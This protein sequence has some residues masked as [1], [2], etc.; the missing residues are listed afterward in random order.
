[1]TRQIE[2]TSTTREVVHEVPSAKEII[3]DKR[4]IF[5]ARNL[6]I[7]A[8]KNHTTSLFVQAHDQEALIF[9]QMA[10][11]QLQNTDIVDGSGRTPLVENFRIEDKPEGGYLGHISFNLYAIKKDSLR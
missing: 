6:I 7:E 2:K 4:Y 3:K 5:M 9:L 10:F 11:I 1:M 8:I